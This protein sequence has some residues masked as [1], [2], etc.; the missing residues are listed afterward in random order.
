LTRE[1]PRKL[2]IALEKENSKTRPAKGGRAVE[3]VRE[4]LRLFL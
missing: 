3:E 1:L 4:S 2:L